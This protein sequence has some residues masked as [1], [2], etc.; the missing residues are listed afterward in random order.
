MMNKIEKIFVKNNLFIVFL[1]TF[2]ILISINNIVSAQGTETYRQL[3]LFG[4]I[5]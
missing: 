3:N 2:G 4:E 1:I 5:F